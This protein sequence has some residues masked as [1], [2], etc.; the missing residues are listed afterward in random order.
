ML[1]KLK[2][3]FK[4]YDVILEEHSYIGPEVLVKNVNIIQANKIINKYKRHRYM[5]IWKKEV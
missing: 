3:L 5:F 4:R 1:N 2:S